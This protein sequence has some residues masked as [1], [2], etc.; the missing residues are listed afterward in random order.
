MPK[1]R[2][3]PSLA[4]CMI[5]ATALPSATGAAG[6]DGWSRA[7]TASLFAAPAPAQTLTIDTATI[8]SAIRVGAEGT[9]LRLRLSNAYGPAVRIGAASV[10][11][12]AGAIVPV[13]FGG[14]AA[15]TMAAGGALVSDAVAAPVKAFDVLEVSLFVDGKAALKTVHMAAGQPTEISGSGDHTATQFAAAGRHNARPLIAGIDVLGAK[16]RPIVVAYGDSITD[17]VGC[18][19]DAVPVCRWGDVLGRRLAQAGKPHVVVTQA[20]GGN[21]MLT[22][23]MGPSALERFDRD[24]L[25]IP[26]VTHVVLLEGINDI[27]NSG[28][29]RAG[30]TQ[31]A[32][33]VA[34]LTQGY[35]QIVRR[36]HARGIKVIGLTVLPF[37]GAG[38]YSAGG[39]AMRVAVNDWIR[40]S[41]TFDAV[42]DLEKVVA[43]PANPKRLADRLQRGDDL[44]P[45]G[46]GE[47]AMGEAIPLELFR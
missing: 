29:T 3:V 36:A 18:A 37:E 47:T 15:V 25:A 12:A 9:K 11:T 24:V 1:L 27:G 21:R 43:D 2:S 40:T 17:N 30:R 34:Q 31:P 8:R 39:E 7:W 16:A 5:L 19:N 38:Y 42:V 4:A 28:L 10:R 33:T 20:I 32:I 13:T 23:G 41:K 26:G 44:H 45:N 46:A 14:Q 6:R 35:A 22:P